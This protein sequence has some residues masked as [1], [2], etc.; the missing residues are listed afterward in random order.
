MLFAEARSLACDRHPSDTPVGVCI[1]CRNL[2]CARCGKKKR[3]RIFCPDHHSVEVMYDWAKVFQSS[4][5]NDAELVRAVL[6]EGG[7]R[8]QVQNFG[9][10]GYVWEGG[11]DSPFTRSALGRQAR[12]FVPIPDYEEAREAVAQ[13]QANPGTEE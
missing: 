2:V 7:F 11:G 4:D 12:V 6:A 10:L 8:V 5:I 3:G 1:I 13:W 9:S